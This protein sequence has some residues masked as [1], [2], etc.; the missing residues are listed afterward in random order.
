MQHDA[1]QLYGARKSENKTMG[2]P[3]QHWE[4]AG[5]W[6]Q[7]LQCPCALSLPTNYKPRLT[8]ADQSIAQHSTATSCPRDKAVQHSCLCAAKQATARTVLS[9]LVDAQQANV[10][11]NITLC[12]VM[13]VILLVAVLWH[14]QGLQDLRTDFSRGF[15]DD[16]EYATLI[17][18]VTTHHAANSILDAPGPHLVELPKFSS[19][20]STE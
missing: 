13:F 14:T 11:D 20:R 8:N 12:I 4:A 6:G 1:S 7:R 19:C 2:S 16:L 9:M 10:S 15:H 3:G 18:L 17:C 5:R